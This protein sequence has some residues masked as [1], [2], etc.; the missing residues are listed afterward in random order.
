MTTI[1]MRLTAEQIP[2]FVQTVMNDRHPEKIAFINREYLI[3][4]WQGLVEQGSGVAY[5]VVNDA[6]EIGGFLLGLHTTSLITGK[7]TA[8]EYLFMVPLHEKVPNAGLHLLR[9]FE[10]AARA[11]GCLDSV[12]GCYQ[13]C[14]PNKLRRWYR[15]NG[16]RELAENFSKEL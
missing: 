9:E 5:G 15:L 12:I 10:K 8:Y 4:A 2:E 14:E 13:I 16:Y 11:D 7:R 6:G 3:S 1:T